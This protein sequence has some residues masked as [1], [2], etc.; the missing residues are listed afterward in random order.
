MVSSS[1]RLVVAAVI[2]GQDGRY[3]LARR[4]P[5]AHLGG[6]WEFP[7]GGVED[8]ELPEQ[9]LVRE[10]YEELGVKIRVLAPRTFAWHRELGKEVLLL[11]Y[12]AEITHG[13]PQGLQG[14]EVAWFKP[15]ELPRLPTPPADAE[16]IR[17]LSASE[18]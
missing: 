12:D 11:F 16:L 2:R 9:A 15:E 5:E 6:L 7:G 4:L 13:T 10:L 1:F 18:A 14:Q 3:L 17:S 8:G